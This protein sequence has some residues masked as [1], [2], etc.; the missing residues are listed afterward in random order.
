MAHRHNCMVCGKE[1]LYSTGNEKV[2]CEY[3]L[4]DHESNVKCEDGHFIC[5]HCHGL[6]ANDLIIQ[7]CT[8]STSKDPMEIALHLMRNEKV[9]MHGPE[10][11]L[12]VPAVLVC[13]YY[14]TTGDVRAKT[15]KLAEARKRAKNVL[16]GFCGYY[17][18][19]GAAVGTGIFISLI[20]D[21]TPL[22]LD[23]WRLANLMTSKALAKIAE[24]GG[25][26]CCK[27]NS[28]LAIIEAVDFLKEHFEVDLPMAQKV[29]CEFDHMNKECRGKKCPFN[30]KAA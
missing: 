15:A 30:K 18:D 14:N 20:T 1:L 26:R 6:K 16:G 13:A 27:R 17:G 3:C 2:R 29:V 28:Y 25:P 12:L 11:H 24:H 5:D 8:N 4:K 23:G 7:F 9:N 22:S 10:H 19:C 21:S